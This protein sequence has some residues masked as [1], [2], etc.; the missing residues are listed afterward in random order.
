MTRGLATLLALPLIEDEL[1]RSFYRITV[2]R[3]G[4]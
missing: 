4:S 2:P 3:L 1:A